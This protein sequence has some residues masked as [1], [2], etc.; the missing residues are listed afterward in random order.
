MDTDV[1]IPQLSPEPSIKPAF[2]EYEAYCSYLVCQFLVDGKKYNK[3]CFE[4]CGQ[5]LCDDWLLAR[6]S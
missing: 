6:S 4:F 5:P 3:V 2:P 1:P